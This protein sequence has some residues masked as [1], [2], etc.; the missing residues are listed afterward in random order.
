MSPKRLLAVFIARNKE[1]LRDRSALA[2]N[3]LFPVLIV[4][5]FA[6]A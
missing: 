2:W 5:G 6:I 4:G 3:I 1:F